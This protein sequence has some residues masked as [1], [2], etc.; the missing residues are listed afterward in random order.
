MWIVADDTRLPAGFDAD[1]D[2]YVLAQV[3]LNGPLAAVKVTVQMAA[4]DTEDI[5]DNADS[6]NPW[7]QC[8]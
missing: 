3:A 8:R 2:T 6:G 1:I 4:E 7:R 5:G